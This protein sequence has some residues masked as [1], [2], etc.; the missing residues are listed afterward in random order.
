MFLKVVDPFERH[1]V[2]VSLG[3]FNVSN[4]RTFG[5]IFGRDLSSPTFA[6]TRRLAAEVVTGI[7][8][9]EGAELRI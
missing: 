8:R 1:Q 2:M 9:L 4:R 7:W 5:L 3:I 6:R